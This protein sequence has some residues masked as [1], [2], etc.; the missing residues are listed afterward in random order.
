[1][2]LSTSDIITYF[3]DSI[4]MD[5]TYELHELEVLLM[6]AYNYDTSLMKNTPSVYNRYV[7]MKMNELKEKDPNMSIKNIMQIAV[8]MWQTHKASG[9]DD[10]YNDIVV[11]DED[12]NDDDSL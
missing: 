3:I 2:R 4:D 5:S 11:E 12:G 8:D 6:N 10:I 9:N 1:M 7:K